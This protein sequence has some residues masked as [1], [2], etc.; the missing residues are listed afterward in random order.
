[1]EA[2]LDIFMPPFLPEHLLVGEVRGGHV[3]FV[4][5]SSIDARVLLHRLQELSNALSNCSAIKNL[6]SCF[7]DLP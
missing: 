5:S 3:Y 2:L 1:M 4:L 7:C 6:E